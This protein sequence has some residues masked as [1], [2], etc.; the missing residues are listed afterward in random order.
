MISPTRPRSTASGLQMTKVRSPIAGAEGSGPPT[1]SPNWAH[2][3]AIHGRLVCPLHHLIRTGH[4]NAPSV[5]G[6]CVR[7]ESA[8]ATEA[9]AP[10]GISPASDDALLVV[11]DVELLEPLDLET[12]GLQALLALFIRLGVEGRD[13]EQVAVDLTDKRNFRVEEV[14]TADPR[15]LVAE[16]DLSPWLGHTGL[17]DDSAE[18]IFEVARW[19]L[20]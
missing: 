17:G 13:V 19:R 16:I 3:T 7:F 5:F 6:P 12:R 15:R 4:T 9:S 18:P 1:P 8:S 14:D 11:P 10:A 20:P 2:Q